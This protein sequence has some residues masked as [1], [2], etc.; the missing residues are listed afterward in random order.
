MGG[1][2]VLDEAAALVGEATDDD[3]DQ[4]NDPPD[5][6][7]TTGQKHQDARADFAD[8]KTVDAEGPEKEAEQKGGDETLVARIV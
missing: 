3:H 6:E 2:A 8:V 4:V 1:L 5:A 7:A